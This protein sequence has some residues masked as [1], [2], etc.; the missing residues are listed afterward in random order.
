[1]ISRRSGAWTLRTD[2]KAISPLTTSPS[3]DDERDYHDVSRPRAKHVGV[4][5]WSRSITRTP[6]FP[7]VLAHLFGVHRTEK[8]F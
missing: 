7:S 3:A 1:L 4:H 5:A 6:S 2:L 8:S